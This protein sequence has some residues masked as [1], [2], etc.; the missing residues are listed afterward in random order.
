MDGN[1]TSTPRSSGSIGWHKDK[2]HFG[3]VLGISLLSVLRFH[4]KVAPAGSA[5][6]LWR[7]RDPR[8]CFAARHEWTGNTASPPLR[9]NATQ[10]RLGHS[11]SDNA[12]RRLVVSLF[13]P[14]RSRFA[15]RSS[16]IKNQLCL[17]HGHVVTSLALPLTLLCRPSC[18]RKCSAAVCRRRSTRRRRPGKP[19]PARPSD[20]PSSFR[21]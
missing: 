8:I 10:S 7:S 18:R 20:T 21:R 19:A 9:I 6:R 4:R 5:R 15:R 3:D 12:A 2:P 1:T 13:P 14:T 11:R 17:R 16:L